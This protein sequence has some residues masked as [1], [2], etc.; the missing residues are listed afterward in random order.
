MP[1]S[2]RRPSVAEATRA[3][4]PTEGSP[5]RPQGAAVFDYPQ[6]G[7]APAPEPAPGK[8]SGLSFGQDRTRLVI[9]LPD[10]VYARVQADMQ[11]TGHKQ[12]RVI[13]D[14]LRA[15]YGMTPDA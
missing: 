12:S 8:G 7:A 11:T 3:P 2:R 4:A 13:A 9:L 15:H 14:A 10:D 5:E 6:A 1:S